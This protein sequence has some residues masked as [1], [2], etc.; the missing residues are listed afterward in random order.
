MTAKWYYSAISLFLICISTQGLHAQIMTQE[1]D[2]HGFLET[3]RVQI[4]SVDK[5]LIQLLGKRE[6]IV[7]QI[8]IYKAQRRIP[9]LQKARFNDVLKNSIAEGKKENL[10]PELITTIMNAIHEESL[11]IENDI[12]R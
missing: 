4:D 1:K 10:S 11:R 9:A 5:A 12:S 3:S 8:G 2:M 6:S 7:R